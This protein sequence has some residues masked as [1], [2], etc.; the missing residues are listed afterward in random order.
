MAAIGQNL[1]RKHR[2]SQ[3][4]TTKTALSDVTRPSKV[5][6]P[7]RMAKSKL[8]PNITRSRR[9][10]FYESARVELTKSSRGQPWCT[11]SQGSIWRLSIR[12]QPGPNP[13]ARGSAYH[14]RSA[15]P[16]STRPLHRGQGAIRWHGGGVSTAKI[17]AKMVGVV[18][19]TV[20]DWV[21]FL[22]RYSCDHGVRGHC[23]SPFRVCR[24]VYGA[25][26]EAGKRVCF[27]GSRDPLPVSVTAIFGI[28][29]VL[30][31]G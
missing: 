17:G 6:G 10:L 5:S 18:H 15:V 21:L 24:S 13:P 1:P 9:D 3:N 12:W 28:G 11:P 27:Q 8:P 2:Q 7:D 22:S 20:A 31:F 4:Q 30:R 23:I 19:E 26:R 29:T 16:H 14:A 25:D